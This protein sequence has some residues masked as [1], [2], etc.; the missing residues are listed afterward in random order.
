MQSPSNQEISHG[1]FPVSPSSDSQTLENKIQKGEH[2]L[3]STDSD[4]N[5]TMNQ[6][7]E[8]LQSP[9]NLISPK[10]M[11]SDKNNQPKLE[12]VREDEKGEQGDGLNKEEK[13][14]LADQMT[15]WIL[16]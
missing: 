9:P 14:I 3:S 12:E 7:H 11:F 1:G 8:P 15:D 10:N 16:K 6:L 4:I 13:E 2:S 5:K